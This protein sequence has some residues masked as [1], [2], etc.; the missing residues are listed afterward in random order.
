MNLPVSPRWF[1]EPSARSLA[2]TLE[3]MSKPAQRVIG[4]AITMLLLPGM[5]YPQELKGALYSKVA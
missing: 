5:L 2:W 4:R 3:N 1:L